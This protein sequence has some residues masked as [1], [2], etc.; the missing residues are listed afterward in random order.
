MIGSQFVAF[1]D[2]F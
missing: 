1:F 2:T